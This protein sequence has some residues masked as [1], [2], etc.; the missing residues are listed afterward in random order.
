M[1]GYPWKYVVT[2]EQVRVAVAASLTLA[3]AMRRLGMEERVNYETLHRRIAALG[4][5]TSH[6]LGQRWRR[7]RREVPSG[8][9]PRRLAEVLVVG[10]A[11]QT[12]SL[13]KRLIREGFKRAECEE[14]GRTTWNGP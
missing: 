8:R 3:E 9:P 12:N 7:E 6:M 1:A 13:R 10:R 4:L 5:D 14:C 11:T 2:D